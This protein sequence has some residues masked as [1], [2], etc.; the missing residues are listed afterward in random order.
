VKVRDAEYRSEKGDSS[1]PARQFAGVWLL[2]HGRSQANDEGLIVSTPRNAM[3][4]YGLTGEGRSQVRDSLNAARDEGLFQGSTIIYASP[5]LRA[6]ETADI[7]VEI[8]GSTGLVIDDRLVER[9]FGG[10]ELGPD[11]NYE[12]VWQ[13]DAKDPNHTLWGVEAVTAVLQ[14]AGSLIVQISRSMAQ[15]EVLLVTHGDVAS[16]LLCAAAGRDLRSHRGY[17]LQTA[18]LRRFGPGLNIEGASSR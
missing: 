4:R 13:E 14:R 6:I 12:R 9:G 17:A 3:D 15:E 10:M 16:I 8:L 5:L 18:E 2:R 1:H 11:A 7:A